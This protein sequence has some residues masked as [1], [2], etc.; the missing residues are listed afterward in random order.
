M[1]TPFLD[2]ELVRLIYQRPADFSDGAGLSASVIDRYG[3]E[4]ARIPTDRGDLGK[5]AGLGKWFRRMVYEALFKGEYWSS[6]G[7]PQW[8]AMLTHCVPM[9]SPERF[10]LGR[11]KFQHFT[12]WLRTELSEYVRDTMRSCDR[13]PHYFDKRTLEAMVDDHLAGRKNYMDE[14]DQMMTLLISTRLLFSQ[15]DAAET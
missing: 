11:H 6:H 8:V 7:M 5:G 10:M 14:I 9:L 15:T 13:L 3:P 1:R 12:R 4:L 2:N